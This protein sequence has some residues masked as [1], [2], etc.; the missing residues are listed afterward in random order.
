M[1]AVFVPLW[2]VYFFKKEC[3]AFL[4]ENVGFFPA[5][6]GLSETIQH[7]L[8]AALIGLAS[9]FTLNNKNPTPTL[10]ECLKITIS[11]ILYYRFRFRPQES[12]IT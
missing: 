11:L 5:I 6:H 12:F 9:V 3:E 2:L 8:I 10:N 7:V 4:L 1:I